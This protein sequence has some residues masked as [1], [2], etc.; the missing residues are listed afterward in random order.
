MEVCC[1]CCELSGRGISDGPI[2]FQRSVTECGVSE[3][4]LETS[5]MRRPGP[6]R[7]DVT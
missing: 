3:C 1:K 7:A 4:D 6:T 2:T 5:A